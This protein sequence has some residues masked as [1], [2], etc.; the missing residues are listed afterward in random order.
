V[1][2]GLVSQAATQYRL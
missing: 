1:E 2:K